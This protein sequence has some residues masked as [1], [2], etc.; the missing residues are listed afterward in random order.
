MCEGDDYWTDP[1]KLSLQTAILD[2]NAE[3]SL[4]FHR[5]HVL[6]DQTNSV[7][8]EFPD[9]CDRSPP[10]WELAKRNFIQTNSVVYRWRYG[11]RLP[12][13]MKE[14]VRPL[15]WLLH[16]AHAQVGSIRYVDRVMAVYRKHSGACGRPHKAPRCTGNA[17]A[18]RSCAF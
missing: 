16:L 4:V 18:Q 14:D 5:V 2:D 13:W 6:D 11:H 15:D 17:T 9:A 3:V 7:L 10:L 8:Y 12:G 1:A